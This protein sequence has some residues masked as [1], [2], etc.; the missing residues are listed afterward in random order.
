MHYQEM[1][2]ILNELELT[3]EEVAAR[4]EAE[5]ERARLQDAGTF[6]KIAKK[7]LSKPAGR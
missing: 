5:L 1:N 2:Q 4:K 6:K 3:T 7:I